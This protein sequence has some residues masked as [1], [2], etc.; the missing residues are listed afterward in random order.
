MNKIIPPII[1]GIRDMKYVPKLTLPDSPS[2]SGSFNANKKKKKRTPE[3]INNVPVI[4]KTILQNF[5]V[6]FF[7]NRHCTYF[8]THKFLKISSWTGCLIGAK[9]KKSPES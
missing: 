9:N 5:M 7:Y 8:I 2:T 1:I 6:Y 4:P 3:I